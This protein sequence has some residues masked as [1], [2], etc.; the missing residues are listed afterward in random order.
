MLRKQL[1]ESRT[2]KY[3]SKV[4]AIKRSHVYI[5]LPHVDK[6]YYKHMGG[7][8]LFNR[9]ISDYRLRMR[10]KKWW[11]R[12]FAYFQ[13]ISVVAGW[14]IHKVLGGTLSHFQFRR[15]IVRTSWEKFLTNQRDQGQVECQWIP[16]VFQ[17]RYMFVFLLANKADSSSAKAIQEASLSSEMCCFT[18]SALMPFMQTLTENFFMSAL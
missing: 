18:M 5:L 1:P 4:R 7:L 13:N 2:N 8:D 10:S 15:Q 12:L 9:F 11:W 3:G 14:R 6:A 17:G 16:P